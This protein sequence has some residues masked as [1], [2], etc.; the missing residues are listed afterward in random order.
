MR[1]AFRAGERVY[2]RPVE[3]EDIESYLAWMNDPE[4]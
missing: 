4:I 2:L 1:N 3:L